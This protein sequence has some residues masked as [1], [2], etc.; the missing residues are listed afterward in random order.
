MRTLLVAPDNIKRERVTNHY[1]QATTAKFVT[2]AYAVGPCDQQMTYVHGLCAHAQGD[3][4]TSLGVTLETPPTI[5][6][7]EVN[8]ILASI[9]QH[10]GTMAPSHDITAM[11]HYGGDGTVTVRDHETHDVGHGLVSNPDFVK[12][13]GDSA[14]H[15]V[16]SYG[17]N[18]NGYS[19]ANTYHAKSCQSLNGYHN[20]YNFYPSDNYHQVFTWTT[21]IIW[22]NIRVAYRSDNLD[23]W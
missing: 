12:T 2:D 13:E 14:S 1:F 20:Y 16:N 7:D 10:M 3:T 11:K 22:Q 8:D 17:A 9:G 4:R 21:C 5:D 19:D 15:P 23:S 6:I 18:W